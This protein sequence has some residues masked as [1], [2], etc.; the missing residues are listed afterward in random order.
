MKCQNE[1]KNK[2]TMRSIKSLVVRNSYFKLLFVLIVLQ[3]LFLH[4][5]ISGL[6]MKENTFSKWELTAYNFG[7]MEKLKPE[8]QI[9]LLNK[10]GYKGIILR[11]ATEENVQN[12]D[13]FIQESDKINDFHIQAVFVRYNF[14][15]SE[16]DKNRW[17][18]VVDIIS[19]KNIQLWFIFG[20]NAEGI[21]DGFIESKLREV[22]SYSTKNKVEVILYPH[23]KCYIESAEEA[24]PFVEKINHPN[25][26]LAFHLYHEI[27]AGNGSRIDKVFE[28]VKNKL[29]AVTMAGTDSIADFSKPKAMNSSTIKPLGEGNFNMNQFI[30]PLNKSGYNGMVGFM[31]FKIEEKLDVYLESSIK[32]W[33]KLTGK[34]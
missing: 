14:T 31:N 6:E 17:K 33:Q 12:L 19:E 7:G 30:N 18:R 29:G 3:H 8:E 9:N 11:G 5:K 28:S 1:N 27:R 24:L 25:L 4:A 22:V 32:E 23:S 15:D 13:A 34:H 10:K 16:N 2:Y 20:K 21:T 26:N